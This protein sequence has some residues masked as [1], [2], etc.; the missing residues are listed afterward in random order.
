MRHSKR[1]FGAECPHALYAAVPTPRRRA[2]RGAE[3]PITFLLF[4][5][6]FLANGCGNV[7]NQEADPGDD[8]GGDG[9]DA[10]DGGSGADASTEQPLFSI[11]AAADRLLVRQGASATLDVTVTRDA[12]FDDPITVLVNGLPDGVT[13]TPLTIDA[14]EDSGTVTISA[15]Q[16]AAKGAGGVELGAEPRHRRRA[17]FRL[18]VDGRPARRTS[19]CRDGRS[20]S[21]RTGRPSGYGLA[22]PARWE[23]ASSA[24][25]GRSAGSVQASRLR[26]NEDEPPMSRSGRKV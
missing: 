12:D 7:R 16:T 15:E 13:M 26:L 10:G 11:A 17:P 2:R 24:A 25:P 6:W 21:R 20:R 1:L 3:P 19:P 9:E 8:D 4:G 23:V 22:I 14:R 18:L 5:L